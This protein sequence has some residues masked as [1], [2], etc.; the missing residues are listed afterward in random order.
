M[1]AALSKVRVLTPLSQ[2]IEWGTMTCP[3]GHTGTIKLF[4]K[5]WNAHS[6]VLG[7]HVISQHSD[8]VYTPSE[9]KSWFFCSCQGLL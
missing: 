3:K 8:R 7:I 1:T 5:M 9:E 2:T 6:I 4:S